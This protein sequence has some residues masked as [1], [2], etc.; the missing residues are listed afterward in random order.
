MENS[1]YAPVPGGIA[2]ISHGA[3]YGDSE[4]HN[5]YQYVFETECTLLFNCTMFRNVIRVPYFNKKNKTHV[6]SLHCL[7]F[8]LSIYLFVFFS[9][10][11]KGINL[12]F[13]V[14]T[15]LTTSVLNTTFNS[16]IMLSLCRRSQVIARAIYSETAIHR[17]FAIR[18]LNSV[19]NNN[20]G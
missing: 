5:C 6:G 9:R 7:Y 11:T 16:I 1:I 19:H 20:L 12:K 4:Q 14:P 18:Q 8:C 13:T 17:N 15:E 2:H 10:T 3:Y